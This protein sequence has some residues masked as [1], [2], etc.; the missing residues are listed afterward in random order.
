MS[1]NVVV[2]NRFLI[3]DSRSHSTSKSPDFKFLILFG[4]PAMLFIVLNITKGDSEHID[5][6]SSREDM[7]RN[8]DVFDNVSRV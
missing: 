2:F 5:L 4:S 8:R 6:L 1:K 7:T 3:C